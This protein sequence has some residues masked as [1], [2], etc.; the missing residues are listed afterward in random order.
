[1]FLKKFILRFLIVCISV[2]VMM[3]VIPGITFT[4]SVF[5]F[6]QI[7]GIF[8][9]SSLLVK[10]LVKMFMLPVEVATMGLMSIVVDSI[11]WLS[12]SNWSDILRITSFWFSCIEGT[13]FVVA[14]IEIH[15]LFTAAIAAFAMGVITTL[16]YWLTK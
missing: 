7:A 12:L 16:L 6:A 14:P 13:N 15:A 1:M 11:L 4:G 8:F 9:I 2:A 10:P 5:A 3:Y